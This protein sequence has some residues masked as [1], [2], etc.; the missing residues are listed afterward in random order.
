MRRTSWQIAQRPILDK[1]GMLEVRSTS[2]DSFGGQAEAWTL[3]ATVW[4]AIRALSG[5]ALFAAQAAQ[6]EVTHEIVINWRND[7]G[8]E[9]RFKYDGRLFNIKSVADEDE[10]RQWLCLRCSEGLT[11]G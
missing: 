7:V 2:Q 4:A 9:M 3:L 10:G 11:E 5:R 8:P 6:S 1:R